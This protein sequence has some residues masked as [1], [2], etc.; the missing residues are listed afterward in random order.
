[1]T[2]RPPVIGI[3]C[4]FLPPQTK[5]TPPR[6]GQNQSYIRPADKAGAAPLLI[7]LL[8]DKDQLRQLF[9]LLDGLLL[10]GGEDV[11]PARYGQ[12]PHENLRQVSPLRDATELTLARWAMEE[13][14][15]LLAICRGIQVLNVALGGSLYQDIQSQL[16]QAQNH[17]WFPGY[18]RN[19]LSHPVQVAPDSRL[20]GILGT[21]TLS[22]NSLHHQAVQDIAPGLE[23]VAWSPDGVCEALE[24]P[25][26]PFALGLQWHPEELV[27]DDP[28]AQQIFDA[29]VE[30]C[31]R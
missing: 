13:G 31:R 26:H 30:A 12:P 14:R 27:D 5:E 4:T 8:T 24:A 21:T 3:T 18:P 16:P 22:V 17:D 2:S 6:F 11:D 9:D 7:P 29:W 25:G 1:M 23:A 19:H 15:P 28:R 10:P 20:A